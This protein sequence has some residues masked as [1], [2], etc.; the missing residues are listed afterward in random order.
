M[1]DGTGKF[2]D[3]ELEHLAHVCGYAAH[4]CLPLT[5][6]MKAD[7]NKARSVLLRVSDLKRKMD[8]DAVSLEQSAGWRHCAGYYSEQ[9][10]RT[11]E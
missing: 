1:A 11:C 6:Q 4:T 5:D 3:S 7:L 2:S 9:I 8:V 10:G